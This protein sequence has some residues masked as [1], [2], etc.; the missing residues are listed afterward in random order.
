MGEPIA[1]RPDRRPHE[2]F[3]DAAPEFAG[4]WRVESAPDTEGVIDIA[5]FIGAHAEANAREYAAWR[6]RPEIRSVPAE[7][8]DA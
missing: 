5:V 1:M 3:P 2:V 6:Y 4:A 8:P 7:A